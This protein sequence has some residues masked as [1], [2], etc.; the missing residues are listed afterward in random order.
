MGRICLFFVYPQ[1]FQFW[2]IAGSKRRTTEEKDILYIFSLN[3]ETNDGTNWSIIIRCILFESDWEILQYAV[4]GWKIEI[5][6]VIWQNYR[7]EKNDFWFKDDDHNDDDNEYEN[8]SS[9]RWIAEV[10]QVRVMVC[11]YPRR[12][13][14]GTAARILRSLCHDMYA[15]GWVCGDVSTIKWK[16][17]DRT[18]LKLGTLVVLDTIEVYWF[19]IQ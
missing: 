16:P 10:R 2:A 7:F 18:D 17:P 15:R 11:Y 14:K 13:R 4:F 19:W 12:R 1:L 3:S 5:R 9:C 6:H 8:V